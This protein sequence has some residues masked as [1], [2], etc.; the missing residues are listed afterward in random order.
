M[1]QQEPNSQPA[2]RATS[3]GRELLDSLLRWQI[4]RDINRA[5]KHLDWCAETAAILGHPTIEIRRA[6]S[7]LELYQKR[8]LQQDQRSGWSKGNMTHENIRLHQ[9]WTLGKPKSEATFAASDGSAATSELSAIINAARERGCAEH[10]HEIKWL[11][12]LPMTDAE[13]KRFNELTGW[14]SRKQ[15]NAALSEAAGKETPK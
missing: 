11:L 10:G 15:P 14:P 9:E 4:K 5:I 3:R 6:K 12:E 2:S 1:N 8:M 13:W 7:E